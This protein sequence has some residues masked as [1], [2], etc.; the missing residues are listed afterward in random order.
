MRN[1]IIV[2]GGLALLF[3]VGG[4]LANNWRENVS[5]CADQQYIDFVR[6]SMVAEFTK[7]S[8]YFCTSGGC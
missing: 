6:P 8:I 4:V 7:K 5:A 1:T 2:G 3:V